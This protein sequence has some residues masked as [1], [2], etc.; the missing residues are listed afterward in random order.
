VDTQVEQVKHSRRNA[1]GQVTQGERSVGRHSMNIPL[2]GKNWSE[3][4]R[5]Q[6]GR[7]EAV[8]FGI[9]QWRWNATTRTRAI[10]GA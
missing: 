7:L 9:D 2:R 4:E 6:I 3:H 8:C 1:T 5:A 10:L